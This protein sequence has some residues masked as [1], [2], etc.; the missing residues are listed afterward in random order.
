VKLSIDSDAHDADHFAY[1]RWGIGT[2]RRGWARKRDVVNT[3]PLR[4]L[5][6]L[7]R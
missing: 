6:A 4:E 2:A 5:L 7:F 3:R 1:L